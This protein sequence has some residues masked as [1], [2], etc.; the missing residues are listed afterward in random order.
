MIYYVGWSQINKGS[1]LL[2]CRDGESGKICTFLNKV[3]QSQ[4][5]GSEFNLEKSVILFRSK[6]N[7]HTF[8]LGLEAYLQYFFLSSIYVNNLKSS[9]KL[10]KYFVSP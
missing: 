1:D 8:I 6:E 9:F 4:D 3:H 10:N 7:E 5:K 2:F